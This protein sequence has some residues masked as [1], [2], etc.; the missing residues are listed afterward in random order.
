MTTRRAYKK[1]RERDERWKQLNRESSDL[2]ARNKEKHYLSVAECLKLSSSGQIPY[3][4]LKEVAI[5]ERPS[6]WSI[7]MLAPKLS[8]DELSETLADYF[9][10]IT[11]KFTPINRNKLP[12]TYTHHIDYLR[13]L[14]K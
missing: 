2:I 11:D 13:Y 7:N 3:Q 6:N 10:R 14:R 5:P 8:D 1:C 12:T 9:V 4:I